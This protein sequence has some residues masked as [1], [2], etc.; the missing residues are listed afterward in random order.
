MTQKANHRQKT[1]GSLLYRD[2][3]FARLLK[4]YIRIIRIVPINK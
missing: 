1:C 4:D 3:D 2:I